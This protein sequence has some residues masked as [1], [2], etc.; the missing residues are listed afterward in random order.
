MTIDDLTT[1]QIKAWI[2]E[3]E[4]FLESELGMDAVAA[5]PT[6]MF[7]YIAERNIQGMLWG[8]LYAVLIISGIILIALK[9]V[10]LGLLSLV[11]NL[12]PAALA[13]GVWGIFVGQ[14]N[15]AVAVVT[16][17]AL[18]VIVDDSVHFLTKY[19]LA[20][21]NEKLSAE[22]AVVSAFSGVGTALLV[23]T[24]ILVAGFAILAQSSFGLNSAM[25]S[26]TAIALFMALV[27]DLTILP[28]LLILLD[29]KMNKSNAQEN[30]VTA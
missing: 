13:F 19:Q 20:R 11:P 10:R 22:R 8:T 14:V 5:G 3:A 23:T 4:T 21:K 7:S 25:A 27:A 6:V 29:R 26:L 28:A 9:D 24:I 16:G 2:Q 30:V 15:M 1:N 18:G 17:M 12:L